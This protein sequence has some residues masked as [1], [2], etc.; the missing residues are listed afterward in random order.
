MSGRHTQAGGAGGGT[1]PGGR[2]ARR[3]FVR[4]LG[5]ASAGL[6]CA[7]M[8]LPLAGCAG[9]PYAPATLVRGRLRVAEGSF[10]EGGEVLVDHPR[11]ARPIL[12][13]RA[14]DGRYTAVST[15]CSHRGCQVAPRGDRLA[16]PCHGSEYTLEGDVLQGPAERPLRSFPTEVRGGAVLID[17]SED[18]RSP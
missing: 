17:L 16:C 10:G 7:G 1:D 3:T 6:V 5:R 15:R 8:V 9:V 2:L 4:S 13:R 18:T 11:D 14:P 12:V